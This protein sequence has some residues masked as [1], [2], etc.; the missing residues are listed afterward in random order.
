MKTN[1]KFLEMLGEC[2]KLQVELLLSENKAS[3]IQQQIDD[4]K[5]ALKNVEEN[6]NALKSKIDL[7]TKSSVE[8]GLTQDTVIDVVT[9]RLQVLESLTVT[10]TMEAPLIEATANNEVSIEASC[11]SIETQESSDIEDE[12]EVE[13]SESEEEVTPIHSEESN[14]SDDNKQ[15][16]I[17]INIPSFI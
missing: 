15:Q 12:Y 1:I 5:N 8:F 9:K 14:I 13:T 3:D 11:S 10:E 17:E 4:L 2:E 7:V 6:K 16:P